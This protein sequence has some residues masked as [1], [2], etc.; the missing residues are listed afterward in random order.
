MNRTLYDSV[1]GHFPY[2][3]CI[4]DGEG[5]MLGINPALEQLLG[6]HAAEWHGQPLSSCLE[7][8]ICDPGHALGWTVALNRALALG[9]TTHLNLPTDFRTG[10]SD[11]ARVSATGIVAPWRDGAEHSGAM[12]I[13][14]DSS[15]Q[16]DLHGAQARFLAVLSHE[17]GTPVVSLAAASDLLAGRLE[18]DDEA[19]RRLLH[20][21]R[22]EA[23]HLRRLLAQF[24]TTLPAQIKAPQPRKD[25]VT[26][27]PI[28]RQVAQMFEVRDLDCQ[29]VME[30]LPD[31]PFVW[32]D[33]EQIQEVLGKLVENALCYA[34][35]GDEIILAAEE[36][37]DRVVVSVRDRG[38]GPSD[39]NRK[40]ISAS[41]CFSLPRA[42]GL[43]DDE[44]AK[45]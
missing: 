16:K 39:E 44:D 40:A 1:F 10:S 19:I 26:L 22:S 13:F 3:L 30:V 24:P 42:Q 15:L 34:S 18:T 45:E 2:G 37:G 31:L 17:L 25:V 12:L 14:H 23:N 7:Q 33:A 21:I 28:L 5:K 38:P 36:Q 29:I 32:S 43:P 8:A 20:T 41:F 27:R 35:P 4:V 11:G 6:W 9:Q